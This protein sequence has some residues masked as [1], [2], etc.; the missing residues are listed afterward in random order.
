MS[1]HNE[2]EGNIMSGEVGIIKETTTG[3]LV[4]ILKSK[5]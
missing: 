3:W 1:D 5:I 2:Q 4:I